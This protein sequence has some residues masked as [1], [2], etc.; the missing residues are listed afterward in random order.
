[1]CHSYLMLLLLWL[2]WSFNCHGTCVVR[3]GPCTNA[4]WSSMGNQG[5]HGGRGE[6]TLR[7]C[8]QRCSSYRGTNGR[9]SCDGSGNRKLG[10]CCSGSGGGSGDVLCEVTHHCPL[11]GSN[12][13]TAV[14]G[15]E[16]ICS[17]HSQ[18]VTL[19][20]HQEQGLGILV[21]TLWFTGPTRVKHGNPL[22]RKIWC[23][24]HELMKYMTTC[25]VLSNQKPVKLKVLID[26][27]FGDMKY[28]WTV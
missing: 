9:G 16:M 23:L 12:K 28:K 3:V 26:I 6:T 10:G 21:Y 5:A 8:V 20:A 27:L 18:Q 24:R 19:W 25:S 4:V 22:D 11:V 17:M 7:T 2:Q 1:M 15:I 13:L 14:T